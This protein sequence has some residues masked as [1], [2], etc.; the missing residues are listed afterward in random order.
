MCSTV[1]GNTKLC[2][3][4][5]H[6]STLLLTTITP[7]P[8]GWH[9]VFVTLL[10]SKWV[11]FCALQPIWT[12]SSSQLIGRPWSS[13][14]SRRPCAVCPQLFFLVPF[15]P[16]TPLPRLATSCYLHP[17]LARVIGCF[18]G[19]SPNTGTYWLWKHDLPIDPKPQPCFQSNPTAIWFL[20][21]FP[22]PA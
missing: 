16:C 5:P 19:N 15:H 21:L 6:E 17:T 4:W 2:S 18:D 3:C 22:K 10:W 13:A 12:T 7:A 11:S 8:H 1:L 9:L 14:E 20:V